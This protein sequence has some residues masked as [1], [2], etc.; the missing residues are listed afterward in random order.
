MSD[1]TW[2]FQSRVFITGDIVLASDLHI[3]ADGLTSSGEYYFLT[4]DNPIVRD[5]NNNPVIPASSFKGCLRSELDLQYHKLQIADRKQYGGVIKLDNTNKSK[6]AI[7]CENPDCWV[8]KVFGRP[9]NDPLREPTR[10]QVCDASI[11]GEAPDSMV[12]TENALHRLLASANPRRSEYVPAGTRFKLELIYTV[13]GDDD[14]EHGIPLILQGLNAVQDSG[15]GG[16]RSR[17]GGRIN[18]ANLA[19]TYKTFEHYKEGNKASVLVEPQPTIEDM[20][21][22]YKDAKNKLINVSA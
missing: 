15:L 5:H 4:P 16:G 14:L 19:M 11:V 3:G 8:E 22:N 10:L 12:R 2:Q 7:L 6:G 13:F 1:K 21:Q 17:G 9:S 20:Q 18:L